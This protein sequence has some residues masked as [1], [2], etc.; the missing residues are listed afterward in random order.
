MFFL[1]FL[2]AI[3]AFLEI[4]VI[5]WFDYRDMEMKNYTVE[6]VTAVASRERYVRDFRDAATF[7][8]CCRECPTYGKRWGCPPFDHDPLDDLMPFERVL[9][10]GAK[11]TPADAKLPMDRVFE[12]IHPCMENINRRLLELERE[13]GGLALGFAGKCPH[14]GGSPCARREGKP[15]RHPE[16]VRPSLEAYGFNVS[17]TA[18][19]LLG[20]DMVWSNDGTVPRYL[21]LVCGLFYNG[22]E[23]QW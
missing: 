3:F 15:C 5:L 6:E 20:I 23:L 9:I 13:V 1:C 19:D 11:V 17:K 8:A 10:V 14:C 12:V 2:G 16:L 18:S 21:T 22:D 7:E 4:I